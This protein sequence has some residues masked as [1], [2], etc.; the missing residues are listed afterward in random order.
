MP[1]RSEAT[2]EMNLPSEMAALNLR[3]RVSIVWLI[4]TIA[5]LAAAWLA[6]QALAARGPTITIT[7][8]NAEG[9]EAGKT[10]VE[11]N[12]VELGLVQSLEPTADF[13]HVVATVQMDKS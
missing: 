12:N 10:K 7:F 11:H 4:P 1:R 2:K 3:H 6:W 8:S 5:A 13:T 9:L